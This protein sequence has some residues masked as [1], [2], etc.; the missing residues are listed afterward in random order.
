MRELEAR[1]YHAARGFLPLLLASCPSATAWTA[2][3]SPSSG[4]AGAPYWTRNVWEKPLLIEIGS[5]GEAA[6]ALRS[7]QR[8]WARCPPASTAAAP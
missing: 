8:N 3:S 4:R 5:V 2:S 1:C 7:I 6:K